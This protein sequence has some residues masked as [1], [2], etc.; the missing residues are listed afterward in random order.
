MTLWLSFLLI[1]ASITKRVCR[2]TK[3]VMKLL[4]EPAIKSRSHVWMPRLMQEIFDRFEHVIGYGHVSITRQAHAEH[5]A[6]RGA[7]DCGGSHAAGRYGD[8]KVRSKSVARAL[9]SLGRPGFPML[10]LVDHFVL[11]ASMSFSHHTE[12][13][14][15][16]CRDRISIIFVFGHHRPNRA[17]GFVRQSESHQHAGFTLQHLLKP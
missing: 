1:F 13:C 5:A 2:S 8:A 14:S 6:E 11:T 9:S 12:R 10:D 15:L 7:S 16:H 4:P 17:R 3:V